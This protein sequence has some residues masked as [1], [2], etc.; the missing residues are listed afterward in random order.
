[1]VFFADFILVFSP[2]QR[3]TLRSK[4]THSFVVVCKFTDIKIRVLL[5]SIKN[6]G[7]CPCP[8]CLIPMD[9]IPQMGTPQDRQQ[10]II[11]KRVDSH[12]RKF[13]IANARR[14]IYDLNYAVD[15]KSLGS[16]LN[17]ESWVPTL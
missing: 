16:F 1:M 6:R 4:L 8:R 12:Q 11:L 17:A 7:H 15:S 3:T 9:R 14:L 5:A 13:N 10:R 2:I